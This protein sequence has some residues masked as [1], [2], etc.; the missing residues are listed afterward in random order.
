MPSIA[1]AGNHY[2]IDGKPGFLISGEMHYFRT[3]RAD[4]AARMDRLIEAGG[5]CL[6]TYIPW[7][8]HEP[9][10]GHFVF[11]QGDGLTDLSAFLDLARDKGLAVIARPSPY[12]YSELLHAGL[13]RWL[14]RFYPEVRALNRQGQVFSNDAV[15]YLH[16]TF[17]ERVKAWLAVVGPILA[18]HQS[19][20][21]GPIVAIQLDNEAS[22]IHLLNGNRDLD[23]HPAVMG[24]GRR[25]GRFPRFLLERYQTWAA[26]GERYHV[27]IT[28]AAD[29]TLDRLPA[30]GVE[31]ER[32]RHD[33]FDCYCT[34]LAEYFQ[35][36]AD[37]LETSGC[38]PP[39]LHKACSPEQVPYFLEANHR[40]TGRLLIG[41]DHYYNLDLT[42]EQNHPTPQYAIRC[43][44]LRP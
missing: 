2:R 34:C 20:Q 22:L 7:L 15:S 26:I 18:R 33:A 21:G 17:L 43:L 4:W 16:P 1:V 39:F 6:A 12:C 10:E 9:E 44:D 29:I 36:L 11:D 27:S 3:P 14:V 28:D 40:L 37:L 19:S 31:G 5:T 38:Q 35:I 13:P 30:N 24:Y 23:C 8:I 41:S 42:W 32:F 25:S